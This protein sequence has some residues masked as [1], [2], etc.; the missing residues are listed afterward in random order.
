MFPEPR[1]EGNRD[2]ARLE[3]GG[4]PLHPMVSEAP[5]ANDPVGRGGLPHNIPERSHVH[6]RRVAPSKLPQWAGSLETR[7]R[8]QVLPTSPAGDP[9]H[10]EAQE[11]WVERRQD[12]PR[13]LGVVIYN[14]DCKVVN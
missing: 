9:G 4:E 5:G 12:N 2:P 13:G 14:R 1:P 3:H 8:A 6:V 7:V 11:G 10:T